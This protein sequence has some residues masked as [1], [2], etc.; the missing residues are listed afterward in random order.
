VARNHGVHAQREV[1]TWLTDL[2]IIIAGAT[3]GIEAVRRFFPRAVLRSAP[4]VAT[5]HAFHRLILGGFCKST[6]ARRP[7]RLRQLRTWLQVQT[8]GRD[9][10]IV[11]HL[12]EI[13]PVVR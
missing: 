13:A 8:M 1:A 2:P 4:P 7:K 9:Q 10:G 12:E 11:T 5:P 6:L 3:T